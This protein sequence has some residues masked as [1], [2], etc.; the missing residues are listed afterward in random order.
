[1]ACKNTTLAVGGTTTCSADVLGTGNFNPAVTWASSNSA[2]AAVNSAGMVTAITAGQAS[3]TAASV[4]TPAVSSAVTMTVTAPLAV[5]VAAGA[6]TVN[7]GDTVSVAATVSGGVG[8]AG[9]TTVSWS[10]NPAVGSFSPATGLA[11]TYTAPSAAPSPGTVTITATATDA[12]GSATGT[13]TI[14][15][16]RVI[17]ISLDPSVALRLTNGVYE[18]YSDFGTLVQAVTNCKECRAGDVLNVIFQNSTSITAPY[19]SVAWNI[20][21][22]STGHLYDPGVIKMWVSGTDGSIS[23]TLRFTFDG[24]TNVAAED[25]TT[26]NPASG[27]MYYYFSGNGT[28]GSGEIMKFKPDGTP[29]GACGPNESAADTISFDNQTEYVIQTDLGGGTDQS[30]FNCRYQG[31]GGYANGISP[32][33]LAIDS[34]DGLACITQPENDAAYCYNVQQGVLTVT[35]MFPIPGIP[36]GSQPAA[37]KVLSASEIVI[38]GRGDNT[39]RWYTIVGTTATPEWTLQLDFTPTDATYWGNH[40]WTGGWYIVEA[41]TNGTLGIMGQVAN[42]DGTVSQKLALVAA[43]VTPPPGSTSAPVPPGV[44]LYAGLPEGTIRIVW[45]QANNAFVAE[46][47]DF[48]GSAPVTRFARVYAD[49]GN[50]SLLTSTSNLVPAAGFLVTQD[51]SHIAVFVN[52]GV[53]LQPN[54]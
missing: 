5:S 43:A 36:A 53:D 9:G 35:I 30:D 40:P 48:S 51:G 12:S 8:I 22:N 37:V 18:I 16:Q 26:G 6:A 33:A 7:T 28:G 44:H 47:P 21:L 14:T 3:I 19:Q 42:A 31:G 49:T 50:V 52:G 32:R 15:V 10:A 38:Y 41:S 24:N 4:Q 46:Y 29:D 13:T 2:V 45:D 23:N 25:M 27:E 34:D 20:F 17:T 54:N 1:M 11:T 39:L